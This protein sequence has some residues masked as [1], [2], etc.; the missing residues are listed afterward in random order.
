MAAEST[1]QGGLFPVTDVEQRTSL[2]LTLGSWITALV[3]VTVAATLAVAAYPSPAEDGSPRVLR[4]LARPPLRPLNLGIVLVAAGLVAAAV[5]LAR[6]PLSSPFAPGYTA[7]YLTR[8]SGT[9]GLLLGVRSEEHRRTRYV[10][11]LMLS[12]RTT[13]RHLALAPGQS[14]QERLPPSSRAAASLYRVGHPSVYRSVS[15][16]AADTTG[17]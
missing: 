2:G 3:L 1:R 15:L 14:W 10:L 9:S 6:T 4:P 11:R 8:D 12:G 5:A 17:R 7:L 13:T 16:G